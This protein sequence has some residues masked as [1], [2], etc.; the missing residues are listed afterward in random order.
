MVAAKRSLLELMLDH[1]SARPS[2]GA[3]W[4]TLRLK[5][6]PPVGGEPRSPQGVS[7]MLGRLACTDCCTRRPASRPR[8]GVFFGSVAPHLQPRYYSISSAP[9]QHPQSV[10]ITC[11]V[12]RET[13]PTGARQGWCGLTCR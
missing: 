1:P 5:G 8:A 13:M 7:S 9:Q 3:Q 2:L 6:G 12:V 11:A 10:H 4:T